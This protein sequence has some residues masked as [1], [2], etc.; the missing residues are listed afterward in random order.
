MFR[1]SMPN[2]TRFRVTMPNPGPKL[3]T[4]TSEKV[5]KKNIKNEIN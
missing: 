1:V 4:I 2:L 3:A 5:I